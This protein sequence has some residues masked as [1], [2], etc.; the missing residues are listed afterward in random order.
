MPLLA[1]PNVEV[2]KIETDTI[3][4]SLP[5]LQT[6]PT[7]TIIDNLSG[8][9]QEQAKQDASHEKV[10]QITPSAKETQDIVDKIAIEEVKKSIEVTLTK[11]VNIEMVAVQTLV[12]L[13]TH[14]PS[15]SLAK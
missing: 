8:G 1:T 9:V 15:V 6:L 12:T 13:P 14:S 5:T 7:L 4:S 10:T 11:E 2:E 3:F